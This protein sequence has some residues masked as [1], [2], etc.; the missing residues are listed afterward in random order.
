[1]P[2]CWRCR[3]VQPKAEVRKTPRGFKCKD[4]TACTRRSQN[5]KIRSKEDQ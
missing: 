5:L 4:V 1:M 3:K 2:Q